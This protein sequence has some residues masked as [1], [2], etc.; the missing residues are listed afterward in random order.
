[1]DF[2]EGIGTWAAQAM[3]SRR[4]PFAD[5]FAN[6]LNAS[7]NWPDHGLG[8]RCAVGHLNIGNPLAFDYAKRVGNFLVRSQEHSAAAVSPAPASYR[9]RGSAG[10]WI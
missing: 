9:R 7:S 5:A 10:V 1:V 8:L 4:I 6:L 3:E 2:V